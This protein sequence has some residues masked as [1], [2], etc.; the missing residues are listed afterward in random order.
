MGLSP[1]SNDK[2]LEKSKISILKMAIC[3]ALSIDM[4]SDK[5]G[6]I[7]EFAICYC[8][9]VGDLFNSFGILNQKSQGKKPTSC[10]FSE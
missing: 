4:S 3:W 8:I 6:V 5:V 10:P 9:R 1:S 2:T 7:Y